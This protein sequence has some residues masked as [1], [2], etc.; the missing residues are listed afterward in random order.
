LGKLNKMLKLMR[1]TNYITG[2]GNTET[3]NSLVLWVSS[4]WKIR[5]QLIQIG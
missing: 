3:K 2:V 5:Q 4:K 1:I